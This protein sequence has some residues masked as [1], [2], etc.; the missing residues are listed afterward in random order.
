M[1]AP[2]LSL[3]L[4]FMGMGHMEMIIV[5][6]IAVLL[7]GNRLPSVARSMGRSLTEFKK[8]M[9]SVT[10]E[11]NDAVRSEPT[12]SLA[13]DDREAPT[14]EAFT[15]PTATAEGEGEPNADDPRHSTV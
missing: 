8:G 1:L 6:A 15:P 4:A 9:S 2:S 7:F 12:D 3:P 11:W 5:G 13:H 10:D 14:A